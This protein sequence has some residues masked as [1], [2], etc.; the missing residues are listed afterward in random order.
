MRI[1]D[2]PNHRPERGP[3]RKHEGDRPD[4]GSRSSRGSGPSSES[5]K[6]NPHKG[7]KLVRH[8]CC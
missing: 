4:N 5:R 6:D 2:S 3:A 1:I 8:A 7:I